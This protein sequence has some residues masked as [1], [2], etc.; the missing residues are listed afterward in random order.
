MLNLLY[1]LQMLRSL[2]FY[3]L[4]AAFIAHLML[5]AHHFITDSGAAHSWRVRTQLV[6]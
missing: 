5:E 3:G 2:L 4:L 6:Q 1:S